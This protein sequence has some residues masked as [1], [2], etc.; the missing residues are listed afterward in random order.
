MI[1]AVCFWTHDLRL[2]QVASELNLADSISH[3]S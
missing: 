2:V 1:R 3:D